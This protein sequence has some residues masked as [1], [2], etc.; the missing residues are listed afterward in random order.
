M[1][2]TIEKAILALS[3]RVSQFFNIFAIN[4][5]LSAV[6]VKGHVILPPSTELPQL[7]HCK[8]FQVKKCLA[9][10]GDG[11]ELHDGDAW[12]GLVI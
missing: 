2:P 12:L 9:S 1:N 4:C 10:H 11:M 7:I 5:S 6:I 3:V 8:A